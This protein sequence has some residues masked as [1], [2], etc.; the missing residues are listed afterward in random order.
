MKTKTTFNIDQ[1]VS[2]QLVDKTE[3][4]FYKRI[5]R[6]FLPDK[7][8]ENGLD[9]YT[10]EELISQG[11][12][13]EDGKVYHKPYIVVRCSNRDNFSMEYKTYE[14]AKKEYNGLCKT[15]KKIIEV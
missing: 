1:I 2:I 4:T 7:Y 11:Y 6:F 14:D 15:I 13:V 9:I 5:K 12:L 8:L 3:A 10:K